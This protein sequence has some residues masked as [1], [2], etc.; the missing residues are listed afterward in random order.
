MTTSRSPEEVFRDHLALRA[1]GEVELDIERNYDPNV[2]LIR[3]GCIY[4]GHDGIR[5]CAQELRNDIGN[6]MA[7]YKTVVVDGAIAFLARRRGSEYVLT[8]NG[9]PTVL[10]VISIPAF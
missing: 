4:H 7:I 6:A 2:T 9:A 5:Q 10:R 1:R 8:A 3:K